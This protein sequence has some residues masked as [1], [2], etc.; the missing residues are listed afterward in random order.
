MAFTDRVVEYPNRY[1]LE[2]ENGVQ[3]GPYTLIRDEGTVTAEGTPLNAANL[4]AEIGGAIT[5]I[6]DA[7]TIDDSQ[8]VSFRNLQAGSVTMSGVQA[9]VI[10]SVN[11]TFPRAFTKKP[12]VNIT[13][14]ATSPTGTQFSVANVTTTGFTIY[15]Y[16]TTAANLSF[17]W[18]AVTV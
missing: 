6:T 10:K 3:T 17:Q 5:P 12:I 1:L 7:I 14:V 13:L 18:Q 4:N 11:V 15:A 2:D 9:K 16:R 8:N